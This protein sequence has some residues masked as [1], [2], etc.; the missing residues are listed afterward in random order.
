MSKPSPFDFIES[1]SSTKVDLI[2]EG[3]EEKE[4]T[5]FL[6]NKALSLHS[7]GVL[8]AN[9]MN[10]W[11]DLPKKL[12]YDYLRLSLRQRQRRSGKW[13]KPEEDELQELVC[14]LYG[15]SPKLAREMMPLLT[16]DHVEKL[17]RM[18]EHG[19]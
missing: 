2:L 17:K 9:E 1:I 16:V 18:K 11:R 7:D 6:T 10:L 3:R 15:L 19:R 5:P 8:Y 4:Y 14:E 12:Q 13:P